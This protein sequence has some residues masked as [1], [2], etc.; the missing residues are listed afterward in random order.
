[1]RKIEWYCDTGL[2]GTLEV[3]D[4]CTD[5]EITDYVYEEI[6]SHLNWNWEEVEE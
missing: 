2:D 1:M 6:L 3:E 4:N 5:E